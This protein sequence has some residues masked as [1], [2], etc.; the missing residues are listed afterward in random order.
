MHTN[1]NHDRNLSCPVASTQQTFALCGAA[2]AAGDATTSTTTTTTGD[3][4]DDAYDD[5][6]AYDYYNYC[7][8][9]YGLNSHSRSGYYLN[10][11]C[12]GAGVGGGVVGLMQLL[13]DPDDAA[14]PSANHHRA[15]QDLILFSFI[16]SIH[17]FC[18]VMFCFVLH[19]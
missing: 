15:D 13:F 10:Y 4:D 16:H 17:G 1:H 12:V 8:C 2:G 18:F 11:S 19:Q 14:I 9:Y 7:Y 6:H 3:D 5:H